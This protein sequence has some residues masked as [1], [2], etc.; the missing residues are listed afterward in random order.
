MDPPEKKKKKSRHASGERSERKEKRRKE[1]RKHRKEKRER[2]SQVVQPTPS[3]SPAEKPTTYDSPPASARIDSDVVLGVDDIMVRKPRSAV[4][5]TAPLPP[6]AN[7]SGYVGQYVQSALTGDFMKVNHAPTTNIEDQESKKTDTSGTQRIHQLRAILQLVGSVG[8]HL[9]AG[10]LLLS[11]VV[12]LIINRTDHDD[13]LIW[14]Y[15]IISDDVQKLL[16]IFSFLSLACSLCPLSAAQEMSAMNYLT[17]ESHPIDKEHEQNEQSCSN[18]FAGYFSAFGVREVSPTENSRRRRLLSFNPLIATHLFNC[19]LHVAVVICCL[20]TAA[21]DDVL[22]MYRGDVEIKYSPSMNNELKVDRKILWVPSN[23]TIVQD[24]ERLFI[25]SPPPVDCPAIAEKERCL[26]AGCCYSDPGGCSFTESDPLRYDIPPLPN[27]EL[28][29]YWRDAARH[30]TSVGRQLCSRNEIC[31]T[32]VHTIP[33]DNIAVN[34]EYGAVTTCVPTDKSNYSFDFHIAR[35]VYCCRFCP[36]AST[37]LLDSEAS[38]SS[39]L[40]TFKKVVSVRMF[41][42]IAAIAWGLYIQLRSDDSNTGSSS[43]ATGEGEQGE[44]SAGKRGRNLSSMKEEVQRRQ[45]V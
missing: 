39:R 41:L 27:P 7:A 21:F 22:W 30:C 44:G 8:M 12:Y 25:N 11:V 37:S 18:C 3:L 32:G 13:D 43:S 35:Y 40:S 16:N 23:L 45:T 33:E 15:Q 24:W 9:R 4:T 10:V 28:R 14:F 42:S 5:D 29:P 6:L 26:N 38:I 17:I 36:S 19:L 20:I 31:D 1:K 2:R 34:D